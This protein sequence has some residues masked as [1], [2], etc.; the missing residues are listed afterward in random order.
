MHSFLVAA[1]ESEHQ[2]RDIGINPYGVGAI[3][4]TILV[5][6]VLALLAFGKG[7]EHS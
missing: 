6:L 4:L 2:L 1:E 3:A 5:V 7:R